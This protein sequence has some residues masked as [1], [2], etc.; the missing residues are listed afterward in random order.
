MGFSVS[1]AYKRWR[2]QLGWSDIGGW[3]ALLGALGATGSGRVVQPGEEIEL[4]SDDLLIV[5]EAPDAGPAGLTIRQG[6]S[7]T[8]R[9]GS[10]TALLTGAAPGRDIVA[11]LLARVARESPPS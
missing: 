5:A 8:I 6:P 9:S 3:T 10:P 2:D 4:A 1:F 7:G 11:A